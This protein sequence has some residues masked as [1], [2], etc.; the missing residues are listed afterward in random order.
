MRK[1]WS[2]PVD[3]QAWGQIRPKP[4]PKLPLPALLLRRRKSVEPITLS[5]T[6]IP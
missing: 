3:V 2:R 1:W 4:F 5:D 6:P